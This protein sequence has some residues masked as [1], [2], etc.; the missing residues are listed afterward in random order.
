M[1]KF[2]VYD[3]RTPRLYVDTD[4]FIF[5][6]NIA[7]E[8]ARN[9]HAV[10]IEDVQRAEKVAFFIGKYEVYQN[11]RGY[12]IRR[13]GKYNRWEYLK[14]IYKGEPAFISDYTYQKHYTTLKAAAETAKRLK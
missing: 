9:G 13:K 10:V 8:H 7:K 3:T 2:K 4:N 1:E 14:S 6:E 12:S 5:A 11:A